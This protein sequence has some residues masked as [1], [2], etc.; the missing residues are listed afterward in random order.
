MAIENAKRL[1]VRIRNKYDSYDN[2]M[3]SGLVLEA[4]EI[5]I[6]YTS[7][8]VKVDNGTAKHPALLMKVG[9]GE[10][11]FANL[12]WLSAKAADVLSVCKNETE[13]TTFVNG[14]IANAG[15]AT[16]EAMQTLTKRVTTAE[17]AIDAL[18]VLVGTD[19]VADQITAA[20]AALNLDTTYAAKEHKHVKAD[21][22]DFAHG[23]VMA[24]VEGLVD[25]LA[26]KETAGEAAKVQDALNEYIESNDAAVALKADKTALEA[27]AATARAAEK[28]NA[29]AIAAINHAE[30]GVL[31]QAK[32]YA[33]GLDSA[34]NTRV[35]GLEAKFGDEEGGVK[36]QIDA[37][38]KVE[39]ERA[40]GVE[41][42]LET[43]LAAV[44]ADYLKAADKTELEGKIKANT[45][46]IDAIEADY[47]K[48]TDK[49]ELSGL[50]TA[51]KER[52]EGVEAGLEERIETM[53]AFWEAAQAD[54]TD[55]N[56]I[57]T[58][59]EIQEYIAGDETGASEM[60]ASIKQNSD[61]IK[62]LEGRMDDAEGEIDALQAD[63]HTHANK[64][65]LDTYTQ[66]EANLADAVAKK[67][68]H[69]N[70]TVLDGI[71]AEKVAAWDAA[72][73]NAKVYTDALRDG[74]VKANADAIAGVVTDYLKAADKT[75]LEGKITTAQTELDALAELVGT[76]KVAD[77]IDAKIEDLDLANTYEAKGTAETLNTAM[78]ARV[79]A[80]EALDF[81]LNGDSIV[82]D[83]GDS[84]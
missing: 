61:D 79:Q 58:L 22:T 62:A 76:E 25:A 19:K 39:K 24:D 35:A 2:W 75:E 71:S 20:I 63:S 74:A 21:I 9:D 12:P 69:A 6:A 52:A 49:I 5:A 70:A 11:T 4:G 30:T 50:V 48:A 44:E 68:A 65:L 28:A 32:D 84:K 23:H 56:V 10:K 83:C 31:A 78:D 26:G 29:D 77:Q 42:E 38:V 66:T 47:L 33:D 17:G 51:E 45:D 40:M 59:K 72:E 41:G 73:G 7:V 37:A 18:E 57:D 60:L 27:E 64:E 16:D 1:N 67:H 55:S 36:D 54:G 3:S 14:V 15:I 43:R 34:M 46:A 53:E 80:L 8:D 81:I 13:L 82:L